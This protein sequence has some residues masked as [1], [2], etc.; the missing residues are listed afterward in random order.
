M[1]S[2]RSRDYRPRI[3]SARDIRTN[4]RSLQG[5]HDAHHQRR[6]VFHIGRGD[7]ELVTRLLPHIRR[8]VTIS[9]V[10]EAGRIDNIFL[11]TGVRRQADVVR[12]VLSAMSLI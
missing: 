3:C 9:N 7:L 10:L 6:P 4:E 5:E 11:K 2:P 8:A 1:M 12:F